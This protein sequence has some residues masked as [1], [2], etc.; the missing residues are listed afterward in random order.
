[1]G[2]AFSHSKSSLF[3]PGGRVSA[4]AAMELEAGAPS[5]SFLLFCAD[6]T[7]ACSI[8]LA[9]I[10]LSTNNFAKSCGY[11]NNSRWVVYYHRV[12]ASKTCC[13]LNRRWGRPTACST[14]DQVT[15]DDL[16]MSERVIEF[17]AV[18]GHRAQL[19]P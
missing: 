2:S 9:I 6:L 16:G 19:K 1:M 4:D 3:E 18:D 11:L 15:V 14:H 7:L 13:A 17:L 12:N 5:L 10:V 8:F